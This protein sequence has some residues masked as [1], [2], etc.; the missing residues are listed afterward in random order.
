MIELYSTATP[1]GRKISRGPG[2]PGQG[3]VLCTGRLYE[4]IPT[5]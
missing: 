1:A 5:R 2:V 4:A 3:D